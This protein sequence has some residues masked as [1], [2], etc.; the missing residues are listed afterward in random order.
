MVV[1]FT[2]RE[3]VSDTHW[4]GEWVGPRA[5]LDAVAKRKNPFIAPVGNR[6]PVAQSVA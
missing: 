1:S 5:G 4:S 2:L 6:T 3:R